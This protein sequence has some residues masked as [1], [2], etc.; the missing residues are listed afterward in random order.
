VLG[1]GIE[2]VIDVLIGEQVRVPGVRL[3]AGQLGG[4]VTSFV[5]QIADGG[6][7]KIVL[8]GTHLQQAV[9][10]DSRH[11]PTTDDTDSEA[12]IRARDLRVATGCPHGRGQPASKLS[13][14]DHF[15]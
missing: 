2:D 12:L 10:V 3:S 8:T 15:P 14:T 5:V 11:A 4:G 1:S 7:L 9:H 13:T 6:E